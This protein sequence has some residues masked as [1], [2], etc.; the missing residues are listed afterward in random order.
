MKWQVEFLEIKKNLYIDTNLYKALH[1]K[2]FSFSF[3]SWGSLSFYPEMNSVSPF[4]LVTF[5][6]SF[7]LFFSSAVETGE[8]G[9]RGVVEVGAGEAGVV[10][11]AE[12]ECFDLTGVGGLDR[13]AAG[14]DAVGPITTLP[15][16]SA[17]YETTPKS[18][19]FSVT[20]NWRKQF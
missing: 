13:N 8:A 20:F 18:P 10:E 12:V 19:M 3:V 6:F 7:F 16:A 15:S 1:S 4:L 11:V 14:T 17:K 2:C 5:F 9:E